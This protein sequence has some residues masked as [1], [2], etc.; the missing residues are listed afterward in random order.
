MGLTAPCVPCQAPTEVGRGVLPPR[1]GARRGPGIPAFSPHHPLTLC[2][3]V[4]GTGSGKAQ[5]SKEGL[6]VDF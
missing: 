5:A 1:W 2:S 4:L 3:V 6:G